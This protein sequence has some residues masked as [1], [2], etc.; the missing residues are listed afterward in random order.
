MISQQRQFTYPL[1]LPP[2]N[3]QDGGRVWRVQEEEEEE[4]DL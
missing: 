2:P 1:S 4:E 3:G